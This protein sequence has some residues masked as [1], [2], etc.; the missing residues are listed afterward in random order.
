M[1]KGVRAEMLK[2]DA[3][4]RT[5]RLRVSEIRDVFSGGQQLTA[6]IVLYCTMASLRAH[7]RGQGR[8]PHAGVLF[9]DNPI[10][11]A[12]AGYL[13]ELQFG[14][15]KAL[16]VQLIYTTGLF[17]AGA[18]STFPLIIRLR[19]DADLRAGR[20]YLSVADRAARMLD[21]PPEAVE[22]VLIPVSASSRRALHPCLTN[23]M[24]AQ[25]TMH[26]DTTTPGEPVAG[27]TLA[28]R[29]PAPAVGRSSA[30][31]VTLLDVPLDDGI[32]PKVLRENGRLRVVADI[33]AGGLDVARPF[34]AVKSTRITSTD[35]EG[36]AS[37]DGVDGHRPAGSATSFVAAPAP[38]AEAG[39]AETIF[40]TDD[41]FIFQDTNYP[42][43]T[44]GKV[45]TAGGFGTGTMIGRRHV[46]T[47]SHV[48]NWT[49][50]SSGNIGWVTFTPGYYD[51][52]GPWGELAVTE[53]LWWVQNPGSL[54]DQ[55]T[56]FDY[57]VL[58]LRDP[59]GDTIGFAG[60]RDY[61]AAW[62]GGAFWQYVGYAGELAG[63]ERPAYQG[64]AVVSS[65]QDFTMSAGG[66]Q[67]NGS[68]L[69]HFNDF[70]PGQSGGPAWGFFG[71]ETAP[72]VI[73]VGS[74]IGSTAVQQPTGSTNGDNELGGG[75]AL[76]ALVSWARTN[77]P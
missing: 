54:T 5:E 2:P 46:L 76:G 59:I 6:A 11:R 36:H 9:L 8:R 73:G 41:R 37:T 25:M 33:G 34:P 38:T 14:V 44:T 77:R 55:Q 49:R 27:A 1:P 29:A 4:L 74:T 57:V 3:V 53:V 40:G 16:G 23:R 61:D 32:E 20:R 75:P 60:T 26:E 65:K 72:R 64:S 66:G 71:S 17:D 63:G 56:A 39:S 48:I 43:R 47:A 68:V 69:G 12:S 19:N 52:R 70:T 42:W 67:I 10:G 50:D 28:K 58:V 62:N 15:A 7:Q 24:G 51:G 13:L 30:A 31:Q 45:R 35:L 22:R 21:D 18:L